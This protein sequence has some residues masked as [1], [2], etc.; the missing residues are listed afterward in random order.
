MKV[1]H[2][3]PNQWHTLFCTHLPDVKFIENQ[4]TDDCDFIYCASASR[5]PDAF[6]AKLKYRKRLICWVWDLPNNWR[7]WGGS[8][9]KGIDLK[10][11]RDGY[12]N[13]IV[14]LLKLCDSVFCGSLYTLNTLASY[15]IDAR[16]MDWYINTPKLDKY[17]KKHLRDDVSERGRLI[18]VGRFVPHKRFEIGIEATRKFYDI[19]CVGFTSSTNSHY[20]DTIFKAYSSQNN[21]QFYPDATDSEKVYRL[22]NS[23]IF[24]SASVFEGYGISPMEA[25]YCGIPVIVTD[26]PVFRDF[27]GDAVVYFEKDNIQDLHK[28]IESILEPVGPS[29]ISESIVE[30]GRERIKY[31]TPEAF[32]KR[33]RDAIEI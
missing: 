19:D 17:M 12:V 33:W 5:L 6:Q 29:Y 14:S 27:Y 1:A 15:H 13:Q 24:V 20:Y 22:I 32:S 9:Y 21:V 28:K 31:C 3:I 26:M 10:E 4:C 30:R 25:L 2:Y 11:N 7:E 16:R 23:D 18:Q 8:L